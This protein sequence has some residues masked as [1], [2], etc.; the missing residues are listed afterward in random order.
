VQNGESGES[1]ADDESVIIG[2]RGHGFSFREV[3]VQHA[4]GDS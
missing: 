1:G 3:S 2:F 4:E